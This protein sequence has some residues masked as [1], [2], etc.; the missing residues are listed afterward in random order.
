MVCACSVRRGGA[1]VRERWCPAVAARVSATPR[2]RSVSA[3]RCACCGGGCACG[4]GW[5]PEAVRQ[6]SGRTLDERDARLAQVEHQQAE[7]RHMLSVHDV[8]PAL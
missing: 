2:A 7:L 6:E 3:H 5:G 4:G 1:R 8:R